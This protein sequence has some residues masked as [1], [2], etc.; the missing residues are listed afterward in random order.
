MKN[1][2]FISGISLIEKVD[3][4]SIGAKIIPVSSDVKAKVNSKALTS[5]NQNAR[6]QML[7]VIVCEN[8]VINR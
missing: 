2:K 8:L 7:S 3:A 5:I 6:E 1:K 4:K